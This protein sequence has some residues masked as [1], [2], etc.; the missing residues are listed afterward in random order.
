MRD[1]SVCW[2]EDCV[3]LKHNWLQHAQHTKVFLDCKLS[4]IW[5]PLTQTAHHPWTT[6]PIMHCTHTFPSTITP[7]TQLSPFTHQLWLP[8]HTCTSFS[9]SHKS[10]T[11]TLTQCEVLF[12]PGYIL[13]VL[14]FI[15]LSLCFTPD[16][17]TL[18]LWTCACDPDFCLVLFTSLPCLWYS[19]F[20][21]LTLPV[22]FC[23][24]NIAAIGST[25]LWPF[26]TEDFADLGSS[27]VI[28]TTQPNYGQR[29]PTPTSSP[30]RP[31]YGG[32][33]S[34]VLWAVLP[35]P[36]VRWVSIQGLVLFWTQ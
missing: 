23:P 17:L 15:L 22:W 6:F 31:D 9:H 29:R 21:L 26:L 1:Y 25:R 28:S 4:W 10:S 18:D 5:F 16:C 12:S 36:I 19:C 34:P 20:C 11:Q 27:S 2:R 13:S 8:H 33:C 7:I 3:K 35:G 24:L 30:G 32:V 14:L